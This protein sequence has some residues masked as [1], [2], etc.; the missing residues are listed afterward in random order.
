MVVSSPGAPLWLWFTIRDKVG[1]SNVAATRTALEP[2]AS[3]EVDQPPAGLV[4]VAPVALVVEEGAAAGSDSFDSQATAN[5][6]NIHPI[7]EDLIQARPLYSEATKR[8]SELEDF[9]KEL[10][11]ALDAAEERVRVAQ[12]Q[13]ADADRRAVGESPFLNFLVFPMGHS[14]LS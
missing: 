4:M 12:A 10:L 9:N 1:P 2:A 3:Q 11:S 5:R 8:N 14:L 6:F 7:A 13:T